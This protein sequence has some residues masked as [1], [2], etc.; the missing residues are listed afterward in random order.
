MTPPDAPAAEAPRKGLRRRT[1]F[2]LYFVV[3][4][5]LVFIFYVFSALN[6]SYSDGYRAGILQ[7]FSK[8]GFICKTWEGEVQQSVVTGVA[9]VFWQF[10]VRNDAVAT[11]L[12]GMVG[13]KV[14]LHYREH[15]GLPTSCWA[16]TTYFVDSVSVVKD[17]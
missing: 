7:K 5:I 6:W 4:P 2:I 17:E 1:K 3:L 15:I 13:Q 11:Q 8:K 10:S 12:G 9:P 16:E 14:N